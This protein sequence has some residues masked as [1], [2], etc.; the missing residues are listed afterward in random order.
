MNY[1]N[2]F[3]LYD[4][5]IRPLLI[6]L[7]GLSG[8]GKDAI[9]SRLKESHPF[10]HIT[11]VTTRLQRGNESDKVDYHF[12]SREKFQAMIKSNELLEWAEVYNNWYG[13]PREPVKTALDKGQDV[14]IKVDVQGAAT[15]KKI[16]PQAVFIFLM[17][18]SVEDHVLRL[19]QRRTESPADLAL[20]TKT[21]GEEL[22]KIHL[23]DYIVFNRH[24]EIDRAVADIE[25]IIIAE[26]HRVAQREIVL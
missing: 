14:V 23:F 26:K 2:H 20:R 1:R 3:T 25:A 11:T 9:L 8:A 18:P 6:V 17:L 13:V 21:A 5:P 15:I 19:E 4:Q 12:V 22:K 16:L 24:G 10:E 7:S